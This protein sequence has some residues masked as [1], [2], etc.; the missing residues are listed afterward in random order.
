MATNNSSPNTSSS[1]C[2]LFDDLPRETWRGINDLYM[3]EGFW[4]RLPHLVAAIAAQSSFKPRDDD[5]VLA[6][7]IKT[8]T[9]W[10]KALIPT[11]MNPNARLAGHEDDDNYDPLIKNHPNELIPSLEIQIFA[12]KSTCHL[13]AMPSPRLF[14]THL[15]YKMLPESL[16]SSGCKMVYITRNPKDAFVSLWHFINSA[17]TSEQGPFPLAETFNKFCNGVHACGPFHDH[18]LEYW[19]ESLK[20]PDK[21]LFMRYEEMT[22]DSSGEVK[23]LAA[24]LGRPFGGEEEEVDKVLW[25]CSLERMKSLEVNQNGVEPWVRIPKSAYFRLGVVGDWKNSLTLEMKERLDGITS[26]KLAGSGLDL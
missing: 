16:R 17:R 21:I 9:T 3:W 13:S 12:E 24:F 23:K 15:P 11:I 22:R 4:Y 2:P 7:S 6:S 14:R 5:I 18:V 26:S 19:K 8:G 20:R 25:R 1:T 10:L